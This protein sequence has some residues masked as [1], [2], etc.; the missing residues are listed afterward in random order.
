MMWVSG[1]ALG[2]EGGAD[3]LAIASRFAASSTL[4]QKDDSLEV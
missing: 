2:H 1:I 3:Q 4:P